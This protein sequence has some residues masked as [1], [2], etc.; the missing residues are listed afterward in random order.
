MRVWYEV[1]YHSYYNDNYPEWHKS[2]FSPFKHLDDAKLSQ[3]Q[4]PS[5]KT[6]IVKVTETRE[7]VE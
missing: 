1:E 4:L 5:F 6:R 7:V 2:V 3:Q